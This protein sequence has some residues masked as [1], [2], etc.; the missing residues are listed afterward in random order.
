MLDMK[1][2]YVFFSQKEQYNYSEREYSSGCLA[3]INSSKNV[4]ENRRKT[5]PNHPY[6]GKFNTMSLI[7]LS[8]KTLKCK[9]MFKVSA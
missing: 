7:K 8:K 5:K 3:K 2:Q 9:N 4:Q 1:I 6:N